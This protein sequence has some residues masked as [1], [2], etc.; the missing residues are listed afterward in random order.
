MKQKKREPLKK[1]LKNHIWTSDK[2]LSIQ[3][4]P[5]FT[6]SDNFILE[7]KSK[8]EGLNSEFPKLSSKYILW[9]QIL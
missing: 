3:K 6:M 7:T 5:F 4:I 1:E 8:L 2:M 9:G